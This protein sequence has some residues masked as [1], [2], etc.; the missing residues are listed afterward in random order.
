MKYYGCDDLRAW[1]EG[2]GFHIGLDS[3]ARD[4][5]CNWYAWRRSNLKAR[6][7]E[8]NGDKGGVQIVVRAFSLQDRSRLDPWESAEVDITGEA[9]GLWYMLKAYSLKH[10]EL[11]ERL[12]DIEAVLVKAW[13]ALV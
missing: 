3:L 10:D 11:R 7:C 12:P 8:C 2:Q 13:N 5:G 9:G 6:A 4:S 1:L